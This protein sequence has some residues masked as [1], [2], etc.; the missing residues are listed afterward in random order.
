MTLVTRRRRTEPN[1]T[2]ERAKRSIRNCGVPR[3]IRGAMATKY[4]GVQCF[5]CGEK[6]IVGEYSVASEDEVI[7]QQLPSPPLRCECCGDRSKYPQTSLIHFLAP[8]EP[9]SSS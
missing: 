7:D 5:N 8:A 9:R 3:I 4:Y 2:G 1:A 6:I